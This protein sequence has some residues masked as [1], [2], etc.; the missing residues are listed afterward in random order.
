MSKTSI[1]NIV[2]VAILAAMALCLAAVYH[3]GERLG[4]GMQGPSK[5]GRAPDGTIWVASHGALHHF[6][7]AG[8][9][10]EKVALSALGRD[11]VISELLPL[12][13]GTLVLA[14]AVPSAAY[15]CDIA[16]RACTSITAKAAASS[17]PTAH[18][19]M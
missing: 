15:R 14:E 11:P 10:K 13:D 7:A 16:A 8:E 1:K 19:L 6:T 18:A 5:I 3:S 17:G 2:A 9:R 4:E 12:S